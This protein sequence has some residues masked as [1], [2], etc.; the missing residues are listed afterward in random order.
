MILEYFSNV[1]I[2]KMFLLIILTRRYFMY[3]KN[4]R[5]QSKMMLLNTL[6]KLWEQH[7]MWTR[8]FIISTASELP[9]LV[10]VTNRL[11]QNP[12]DFAAVLSKFYGI[13][14][15]NKFKELLTQHLLIGADLVNAAK[16]GDTAKAA[17]ARKRWYENAD[18][19]AAFL[20]SINPYWN[21]KEWQTLLY[22][23][24][25]M[26]ENEAA[27]RLTGKYKDDINQYDAIEDEA[28]EMADY[29]YSGIVNQFKL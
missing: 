13:Q 24:L 15:A 17:D 21:Q 7:V 14:N 12:G 23:H 25:K 28:L 3:R 4:N 20:A 5:A 11:L 1:C 2:V 8:S 29:M 26:T 27:L 22:D 6:R 16:Q 19:I 10:F 18:E 9:D